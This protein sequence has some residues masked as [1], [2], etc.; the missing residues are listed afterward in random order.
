MASLNLATL[1]VAS[2]G[3]TTATTAYADG[4]QLGALMTFTMATATGII[5]GAVLTDKSNIVGAVDAF[6]YDRSVTLA[7]DN[8]PD[9]ISDADSFF[10]LGVIPFPQP[11]PQSL[12]RGGHVD[13]LGIAYV[14]N[15][16]TVICVQLVTRSG[17]T[18]FGAAGDLQLRLLYSKDV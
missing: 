17:H 14:A 16:T 12:N 4:D 7:A 18:F 8:A 15:A 2:T 1:P 13:S 5:T 10:K 11:T 3:L 9:S 6:I